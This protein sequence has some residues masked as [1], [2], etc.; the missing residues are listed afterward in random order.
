MTTTSTR[1][2]GPVTLHREATPAA[3]AQVDVL[4]MAVP[5]A[6]RVLPA[7]LA[8]YESHL[9]D[10]TAGDV[11][12]IP[13]TADSSFHAR[14]VDVVV[15]GSNTHEAGRRAGRRVGA[16]RRRAT[17][18]ALGGF[19]VTG[20]S[21]AL[22]GFVAGFC[23]ARYRY[24]RYRSDPA[25]VAAEL[26]VLDGPD[27]RVDAADAADHSAT[28]VVEASVQWCRDLTNA[29][30]SDLTPGSFAREIVC[31]FED[32]GA[33]VRVLDATWLTEEGFAGIV[34]VG[35]GSPH[36][37]CLVEV[38]Y[39]GPRATHT[40]PVVLVGKGVT[41]DSGGLSLKKASAMVDMKSDMAGAA[42]VL[43][44]VRA[45]AQLAPP[46]VHVVALAALAENLPGPAALRPGD[47]IRH[48]NGLTTE[49]VNTDCEGRLVMSDVLSFAA[50]QAPA[51]ILDVATLTYSTIAALGIEITSV[52]GNDDDLVADVRRAGA[53][54]GDPYWQLPLW[55]PYRELIRSPVADLRN[56]EIGD[57]AGVITA[58]LYLREFVG[59]RPWAHLD[60][61]GTAYL[62]E[63]TDGL[64]PG[65]TGH[66]V[67]SLVRFVLDRQGV[68]GSDAS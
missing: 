46:D 65:A 7:W 47:V 48:R 53:A 3:L 50:E 33:S 66:G 8:P 64:E 11:L 57:G 24:G 31:E 36:P 42:T 26:R 14:V 49:V 22:L 12:S 17:H 35:A 10:A 67:R 13:G 41:F 32:S 27:D 21:A 54:V 2:A 62:E 59:D 19:E 23:E 58:A 60:T 29:P 34:S 40:P 45:L 52:I 18:F 25:V 39:R 56:E 15:L 6:G 16:D 28:E 1:P 51:A 4:V 55:A 30:A 43:A 38:T 37:P 5:V 68:T 44:A 63:K 61:G 20:T 9:S